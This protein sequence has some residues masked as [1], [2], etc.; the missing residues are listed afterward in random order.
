MD[1]GNIIATEDVHAASFQANGFQPIAGASYL[2]EVDHHLIYRDDKDRHIYIM[3]PNGQKKI[4]MFNGNAGEVYCVGG[5]TYLIDF[6]HQSRVEVLDSGSD[7]PRVIT[8]E[9]VK[10]FAVCNDSIVYL[11]TGNELKYH[12]LKS[13]TGVHLADK[14]QAFFLNGDIVAQSGKN[15]IQFTTSGLLPEK[16][17]TS[18]ASDFRLLGATKDA[19]YFQE[20]GLL[21]SLEQGERIEW[22]KN[23]HTLYK[24]LL[25]VDENSI[26]VVVQDNQNGV[27]KNILVNL[28]RG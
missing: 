22:S 27:P 8:K 11:T 1:G 9:S 12:A 25:I 4:A 15:I 21:I 10:S 17:Y 14:I 28:K 6:G 13:D 5:Q 20:D 3:Q 18:S 7:E 2:N 16:V 24:S 23:K 26:Y 19:V